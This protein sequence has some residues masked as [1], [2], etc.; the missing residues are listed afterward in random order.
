[1]LRTFVGLYLRELGGWI[2]VAALL[3]LLATAGVSNSSARSAVSRL[4]G[5]GLL[6]PEEREAV[7]GYRLDPAAVTDLERGDRRIFSYRGQ[8]DDEPWCLVSYSVPEVDRSKRVQ[9]RRALTGLGFGAVT[10]GLWIA[11]GHLRAEVEDAL[12]HLD[13]RERATI[14]ITATPLTAEPFAQTA[15]K[16]WDLDTLAARHTEFLHRYEL[17]APR[18]ESSDPQPRPE[19]R[20]A[21]VLWLRC[22]DDWK[23]IPYVDPGLPPSALP[24]G[25]PGQRSVT[26]FADL[27]AT[28]AESARDHVRKVAVGR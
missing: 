3:E 19:P 4:K 2:R 17:A 23:M 15:A 25:W 6:L 24:A 12:E 22:V 9:L 28:Y 18:A 16:W 20:E 21:F 11:P 5:K 26:L 14:F 7:A 10:D 8:K 1:M 27:R 13:V